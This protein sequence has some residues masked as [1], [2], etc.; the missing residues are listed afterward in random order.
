MNVLKSRLPLIPSLTSGSRPSL[1]TTARIEA[2][3]ITGTFF[4]ALHQ[5]HLARALLIAAMLMFTG[6]GHWIL[7]GLMLIILVA[8]VHDLFT[9]QLWSEVK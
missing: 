6:R 7:K 3:A 8:I 1:L 9:G 2:I 5:G 4:Y